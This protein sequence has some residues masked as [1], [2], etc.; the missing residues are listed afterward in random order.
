MVQHSMQKGPLIT[1][2]F[3]QKGHLITIHTKPKG[4]FI[5]VHSKQRPLIILFPADIQ[6][7][8]LVIAL[9]S[10]S[11]NKIRKVRKAKALPSEIPTRNVDWLESHF[12]SELSSRVS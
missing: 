4:P 8:P 11:R 2:R 12:R 10:V 5:D 9:F 6:K 7:G 3:K 1:M